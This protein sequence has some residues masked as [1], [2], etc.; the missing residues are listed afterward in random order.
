MPSSKGLLLAQRQ[1]LGVNP[2]LKD[3]FAVFAFADVHG[4][5]APFEFARHFLSCTCLAEQLGRSGRRSAQD[6]TKFVLRGTADTV[7]GQEPVQPDRY[8]A[9]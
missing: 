1:F 7:Y 8:T 9:P 4:G 6:G 3:D 5:R 2:L